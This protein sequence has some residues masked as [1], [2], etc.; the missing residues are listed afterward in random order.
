MPNIV[1]YYIYTP[2]WNYKHVHSAQWH[3]FSCVVPKAQR[4]P[5]SMDCIPLNSERHVFCDV[6]SHAFLYT[7]LTGNLYKGS[8]QRTS[9]SGCEAQTCYSA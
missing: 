6:Y 1:Y 4:V 7:Q 3:T 9:I 8:T 2:R 5:M